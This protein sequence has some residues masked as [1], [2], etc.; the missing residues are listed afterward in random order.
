MAVGTGRIATENQFPRQTLVA[1]QAHFLCQVQ[2]PNRTHTKKQTYRGLHGHQTAPEGTLG[3]V[4]CALAANSTKRRKKM[5]SSV[6]YKTIG[7]FLSQNTAP[8][9]PNTHTHKCGTNNRRAFSPVQQDAMWPSGR[10]RGTHGSGG[11]PASR[12]VPVPRPPAPCEQRGRCRDSDAVGVGGGSFWGRPTLMPPPPHVTF[13]R[14][15][16]PLQG[17]GQSP[18]L[19][20][21]CCVGSLLSVGRCVWCSCWCRFR[22]RGAQRLVCWGCAE[23]GMAPPTTDEGKGV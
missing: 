21:A 11:G 13:R 7:T 8:P 10:L 23:C 6:A 20:F 15:V 2:P 17:P 9:P 16:A 3:Y 19:P 1:C 18:G 14:V 5:G 4:T 12:P 22:V